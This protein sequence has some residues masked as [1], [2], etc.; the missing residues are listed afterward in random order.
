MTAVKAA[1]V[2]SAAAQEAA[3]QAQLDK[4]IL[5]AQ[6]RRAVAEAAERFMPFVK[7][8]IPDPEAPDDPTRSAYENVRHH[9]AIA[10]ALE[11]VERGEIRQ[12]I[13]TVP[14]RH[15]KSE[16]TTRRFPAWVSGR[17]PSWSIAIGSY[18]D[19]MATDF[20]AEV[21]TILASPMF[22]RAFPQYSLQRGGAAKDHIATVNGGHL[23]FVG[24]GG[25]LTGRGAHLVVID[26]PFKDAEEARSQAT[27][28]SA[29]D[30]FTKVVMSRRM[31]PKLVLIVMTR[32]HED[33]IVGRLT[34][35]EN[36]HYNE[37]EARTWKIINLP[38]IA[39]D[40]DPL[41][42]EPG[43]PLWPARYDLAFLEQ[44]RR[45]DPLGFSALYQ[46]RPTPADGV[47]FDR[48]SIRLYDRSR[49]PSDLRIY[50]ASDH[51]VGTKQANDWTVLLTVGVDKDQNIYVLDCFWRKVKTDVTVEAMLN[52]MRTRKPL[53]WWAERG[54]I[55][56]SIGPFLRKRMVETSTFCRLVEVTPVADKE[57]RA[58]AIAARAANGFLHLPK[59]APWT[60][61]AL[62]E[63]L[64][65]PH[66]RHDD[67][68][69]ALAYIG[70]GL[71]SVFGKKPSA[72]SQQPKT[73]TLGWIKAQTARVERTARGT[74][75]GFT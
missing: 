53:L 37:E 15:G 38:A 59:D 72:A 40:D 36:P 20:G 31:G 56:K 35:P 33:D 42:R 6:A 11:A 64:K 27:R 63:L 41:G 7:Y 8:T 51:A 1:K 43:E 50:A 23:F 4:A 69:D 75:G 29:W 52:L 48:E 18:S 44:A 9:D 67:F 58:Q 25:A 74:S 26:D 10:E 45:L 70:L 22:K 2:Q 61:K 55:S 73:G 62:A 47:L 54:H 65:F 34:D 3:L 46:Q 5:L 28:D 12:L 13:L 66:G 60:A 32:W 19:T 71:G 24:R 68:V 14:P 17:H 30:W 16:L 49:L 39:D 57:A 21:R